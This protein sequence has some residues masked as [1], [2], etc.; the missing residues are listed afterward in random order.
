MTTLADI[1]KTLER[2]EKSDDVNQ[3]LL[4][5]IG[6]VMDEQLRILKQQRNESEKSEL[7]GR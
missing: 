7:L 1:N 3:A 5:R 6:I 2:I 4:G